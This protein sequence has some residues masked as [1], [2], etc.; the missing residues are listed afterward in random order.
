MALTLRHSW[1]EDRD[2]N[3]WTVY[4]DLLERPVGR[5]YENSAHSGKAMWVWVVHAGD[6]YSWGAGK[7]GLAPTLEKAKAAVLNNWMAIM[8][9]S[10]E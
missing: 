2:R 1:E 10:R 3:D 7:S 4:D 6:A 9:W 5:I 8:G